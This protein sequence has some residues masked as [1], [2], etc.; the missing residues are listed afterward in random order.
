MLSSAW[1]TR[2]SFSCFSILFF[3]FHSYV[4]W[5]RIAGSTCFFAPLWYRLFPWRFSNS[6][7][8]NEFCS[9]YYFASAIIRSFLGV[10][11]LI[12]NSFLIRLATMRSISLITSAGNLSC[13]SRL[14]CSVKFFWRDLVFRWHSGFLRVFDLVGETCLHKLTLYSLSRFSLIIR[15]MEACLFNVLIS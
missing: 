4:A 5:A 14:S 6:L 12:G 2:W 13:C 15:S 11:C 10:N 8:L 9:C 1:S 7:K 3:C